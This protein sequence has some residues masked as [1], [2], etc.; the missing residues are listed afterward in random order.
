MSKV[1]AIMANFYYKFI[2]NKRKDDYVKSVGLE[3][4]SPT[5]L[6][7]PN[8]TDLI[9]F[10]P[11]EPIDVVGKD[12]LQNFIDNYKPTDNYGTY[13]RLMSTRLKFDTILNLND[14][15]RKVIASLL[16]ETGTLIHIENILGVEDCG[17]EFQYRMGRYTEDETTALRILNKNGLSIQNISKLM[18]RTEKSIYDKLRRLK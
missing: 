18:N 6:N 12:S 17:I 4:I 16:K 7:Q 5:P 2:K 9:Y 11:D 15:S 8:M 14:R 13:E 10:T 1:T 3:L